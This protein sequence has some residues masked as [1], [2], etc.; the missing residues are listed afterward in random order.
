MPGTSEALPSRFGHGRRPACDAD[1]SAPSRPRSVDCAG[2]D[3]SR[4][5]Y[6]QPPR[7]ACPVSTV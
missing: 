6:R 7:A 5:P 1:A 2:G 3:V 4:S